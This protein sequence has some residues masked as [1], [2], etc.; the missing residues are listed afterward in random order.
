MKIFLTGATSFI[1]RYLAAELVKRNHEVYALVRPG[2]GNESKCDFRNI[3]VIRHD[4]NSIEEM[5]FNKFPRMDIFI[6]LAWAGE[7]ADDRMNEKIQ[8]LNIKNTL[9]LISLAQ[10]TGCKRFIFAGSQAEYGVTLDRIG[11]KGFDRSYIYDENLSCS[12]VSEYGKAKLRVLQNACVLC[13]DM[14]MEYIHLRLFSIYG[15]G[16]HRN[17]LVSTCIRNLLE[18]KE[19]IFGKC[20]QLW[21][22]LYVTDCASAIADL[23]QCKFMSGRHEEAHVVNIASD[24]TRVLKDFVLDIEDVLGKK[25]KVLFTGK[26]DRKEGIPYLNPSIEKLKRLTGFKAGVDFNKGIQLI[27]D[28]M[29][30]EK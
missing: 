6:H 20:T 8:R 17:S 26:N 24:T 15:T 7:G 3:H 2:S 21:N 29:L 4:M 16:D 14:D 19:V 22:Y 12:P 11:K 13:E 25:G 23:A 28:A 27:R 30:S 10:V 18:D 9:N 5:S 1:G